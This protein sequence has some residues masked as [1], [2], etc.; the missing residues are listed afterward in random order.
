MRRLLSALALLA[1]ACAPQPSVS[2]NARAEADAADACG[3]RAMSGT[4]GVNIAA[5]TFPAGTRVI[6]PGAMV[7]EDFRPE[8][9]NVLVDANGN[10]T[11]F[12]CY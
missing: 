5:A 10:I 12:G 2:P 1:S 3:A 11:G 7:T 9:L 4:V 8:R 6:R